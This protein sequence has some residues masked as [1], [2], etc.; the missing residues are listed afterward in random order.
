[1][2]LDF[3]SRMPEWERRRPFE[4]A[5]RAKDR[6]ELVRQAPAGFKPSKSRKRVKITLIAR[7]AKVKVGGSFWYRI[8]LRNMGPEPIRWMDHD[9][10]FFKH[11]KALSDWEFR[12]TLPNGKTK[13]MWVDRG[14]HCGAEEVREVRGMA[15]EARRKYIEDLEFHD[16]LEQ[17]LDVTLQPGETLVTRPWRYYGG[18]EYCDMVKRGEDPDARIPGEF[19]EFPGLDPFENLGAYHI[20]AVWTRKSIGVLWPKPPPD[21]FEHDKVGEIESNE[22]RVEVVP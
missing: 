19:R 13:R 15:K 6:A 5:Q 3:R 9:W 14:V 10:S 16:K 22:V 17:G 11:G 4:E 12:M 20:K 8:E 18:F 1:M 2:I 7:D 21:D